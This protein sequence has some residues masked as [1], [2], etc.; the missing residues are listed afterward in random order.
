MAKAASFRGIGFLMG[1]LLFSAC[2]MSE[3][4]IWVVERDIPQTRNLIPV[5]NRT[6]LIAA[7]REGAV[8]CTVSWRLPEANTRKGP[9]W[10]EF[11][12]RAQAGLP[13]W[14]P[15]GFPDP[16]PRVLGAPEIANEGEDAIL[17]WPGIELRPGKGAA[18]YA[19]TWLGPPDMYHA[20]S[21]L[22]FGD[23]RVDSEYSAAIQ[24]AASVSLSCRFVL[25]NTFSEPLEGLEFAFFFPRA[26]LDNET[27]GEI[28]LLGSFACRT[29]G[30]SDSA[31]LD[32]LITDGLGRAAWGP[33]S[34]VRLDRLEAGQSVA[35]HVDVT[36]KMLEGE[37][38]IVPLVSFVG[39]I[40]S[41]YRPS[42]EVAVTPPS[43]V[44]YS[45]FTHF[46]LVIA[47]SRLFRIGNGL[48]DVEASSPEVRRALGTGMSGRQ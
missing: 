10:P 31:P 3:S 8:T 33:R 26:L 19:E 25:R 44:H 9:F 40:R 24:G 46:N 20:A 11:G 6:I 14:L 30:F 28:P 32:L 38:L 27:G 13:V 16:A 4:E 2:H 1:A 43:R 48:A 42:S 41:R 21:G 45:D 15:E 12:F 5:L 18:I 37:V 23:I 7:G 47:D 34:A 22:A 35:C 39:R 36:G 29:E 17:R